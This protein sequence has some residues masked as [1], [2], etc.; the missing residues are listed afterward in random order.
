MI[1]PVSNL[2][3]MTEVNFNRAAALTAAANTWFYARGEIQGK[4][5]GYDDSD[6]GRLLS[7]CGIITGT[8]NRYSAGTWPAE[9][10][11]AERNGPFFAD[12]ADAQL[13]LY[14]RKEQFRNESHLSHDPMR[15]AHEQVSTT[16]DPTGEN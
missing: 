6:E 1:D 8:M 9:K 10:A 4:M 12:D 2:G 15:R 7:R 11:E 13:G 16:Y 3:H 14:E 5:Y